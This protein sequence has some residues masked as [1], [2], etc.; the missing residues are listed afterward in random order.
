M[1]ED[2]GDANGKGTNDAIRSMRNGLELL[3]NLVYLTEREAE[4]P[5][6]VRSYMQMAGE[7][8][9]DMVGVFRSLQ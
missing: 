5:E 6:K 4:Y 3:V 8:L 7:R 1:F 2:R 9:R